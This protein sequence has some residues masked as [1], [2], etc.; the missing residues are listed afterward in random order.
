[1]PLHYCGVLAAAAASIQK[2]F[3]KNN[4]FSKKVFSLPYVG[5]KID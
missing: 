1:V 2:N 5:L 3:L 4:L